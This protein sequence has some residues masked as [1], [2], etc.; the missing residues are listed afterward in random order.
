[1]YCIQMC[2]KMRN[3]IF[4]GRKINYSESYFSSDIFDANKHFS[5][6]VIMLSWNN[7]ELI[8]KL[9]NLKL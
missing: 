7:Q 8:I 4:G 3:I 2:R 5:Y 9:I 1:M 6:A